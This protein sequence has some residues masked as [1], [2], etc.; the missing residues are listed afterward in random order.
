MNSMMNRSTLREIKQSLGRYL[1]ILSIVALG[2]GFFAGIKETK[3]AMVETA[4]RYLKEKNFYDYRLVSTLGFDEK[5]VEEIRKR[6]DV[7]VAQGAY[8]F[9]ILC[10]I[11]I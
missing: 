5:I 3:P 10:Q 11:P 4:D 8:T 1:A 9:D 2:V 6:E 7:S